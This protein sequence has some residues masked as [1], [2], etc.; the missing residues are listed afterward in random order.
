M[1][2]RFEDGSGMT[3]HQIRD[4]VRT[5]TVAGYETVAEALAWASYLIATHPDVEASL[6]S[7]LSGLPDD[8]PLGI[9]AMS[10]LRYCRMIL[11]EAM[12]LYP[13]TWL[14]VRVAEHDDVLPTGSFIPAG[15]KIYLSQWVLHRN[16]RY[17]PDPERFDPERFTD[18]AIRSRP[19]FTYIPFGAGRRLCIGEDFAWMQAVLALAWIM[20]RFRLRLEPGQTIT[21]EPNVT[22]RPRDG[23]RMRIAPR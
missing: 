5:L 10:A 21:P 15:A 19:R 4:E 11:A 12:R 6:V 14:F 16:P 13:P 8:A 18:N 23:I 9:E 17:F 7:E 1:F 20:R 3:D 22:L 2:A